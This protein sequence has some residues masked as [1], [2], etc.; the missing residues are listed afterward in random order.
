M[1]QQPLLMLELMR[2]IQ[3]KNNVSRQGWWSDV[4][5]VI[6]GTFY[7]TWRY[8]SLPREITD[9]FNCT[10]AVRVVY[11]SFT[12]HGKNPDFFPPMLQSLI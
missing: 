6:E 8:H 5:E 10:V 2:L 12:K 9:S 7:T 11:K 1:K 3:K 4:N